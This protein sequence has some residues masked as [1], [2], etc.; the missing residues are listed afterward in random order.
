VDE[1]AETAEPFDVEARAAREEDETPARE[2]TP[3]DPPQVQRVGTGIMPAVVTS[4]VLGAAMLVFVAQNTNR[5]DLEWLWLDFH[6]SAGVLALAA[7]FVGV[8]AAIV[9]GA[10][11]RRNRRRRLNEREEL[12]RLRRSATR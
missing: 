4:I 12:A 7:L 8:V 10:V 3:A 5:I 2:A 11:V 9:G 6:T 1:P